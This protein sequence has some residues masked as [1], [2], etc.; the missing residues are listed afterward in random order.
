MKTKLA[1]ASLFLMGTLAMSSDIV[2]VVQVEPLSSQLAVFLG[3]IE[4]AP[5]LKSKA[6]VL[7]EIKLYLKREI[8]RVVQKLPENRALHY[9]LVALDEYLREMPVEGFRIE[10]CEN[11]AAALFT[12]FSPRNSSPSIL[13]IPA[14]AKQAAQILATI[15]G[16]PELSFQE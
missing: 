8:H 9:T 4:K 6:A 14:E 1:L 10:D 5:D 12:G 3:K 16:K 7:G 11:Q 2:P 13:D 15:C